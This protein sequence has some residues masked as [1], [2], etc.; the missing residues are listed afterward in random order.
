M[1]NALPFSIL[2]SDSSVA[3]RKKST[4]MEQTLFQIICL[5]RDKLNKISK[6]SKRRTEKHY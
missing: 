1:K 3:S 2:H 4:Y 6:K 5:K